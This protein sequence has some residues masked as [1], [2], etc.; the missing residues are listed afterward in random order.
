MRKRIQFIMD[1]GLAPPFPVDLTVTPEE[2]EL[3]LEKYRPFAQNGKITVTDSPEPPPT[4]QERLE[5]QVLYTAMMTDTLL[6]E[7]NEDV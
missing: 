6:L 2:L 7:E 5:S 1:N 3:E 4:E